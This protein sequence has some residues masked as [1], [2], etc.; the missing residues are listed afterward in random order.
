MY[1]CDW[2]AVF[3]GRIAHYCWGLFWFSSLVK[4]QNRRCLQATRD[5]FTLFQFKLNQ[6]YV[7]REVEKFRE[8]L[9]RQ[10]KCSEYRVPYVSSTTSACRNGAL[11][12]HSRWKLIHMYY[13]DCRWM[14][15]VAKS[16][17]VWCGRKNVALVVWSGASRHVC[18]W[19]PVGSLNPPK[20]GRGPRFSASAAIELDRP[21]WVN[22]NGS[23]GSNA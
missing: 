4:I 5:K 14:V 23:N 9:T 13:V 22:R 21:C 20:T 18:H 19:V 2:R 12:H 3:H 7:C 17:F 16:L 8:A 6:K 15:M 10:R 11:G 1:V